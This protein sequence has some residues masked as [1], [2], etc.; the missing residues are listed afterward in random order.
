MREAVKDKSYRSTPVGL[1]VA[2]FIR[3]FRNEYGATSETLRDYE[4][5]LAK[6]AIDH[7]DLDLAAFEPPEGTTGSASSSTSAGATQHRAPVRKCA[8]S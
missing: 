2:Q 5:I 3:W 1:E 8:P 4:G 7:A 6:L